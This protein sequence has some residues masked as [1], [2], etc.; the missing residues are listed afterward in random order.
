MVDNAAPVSAAFVISA[1]NDLM[2]ECVDFA[3]QVGAL[4]PHLER[5][6]APDP[7]LVAVLGEMRLRA[8]RIKSMLGA[9]EAD[10][11]RLREK[12]GG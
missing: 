7:S 8:A 5:L 2:V 4:V 9:L 3:L 1:R 6:A 11:A 10:V 12:T